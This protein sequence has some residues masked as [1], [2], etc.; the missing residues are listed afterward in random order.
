MK[1]Q[2]FLSFVKTLRP[3]ESLM[4]YVEMFQVIAEVTKLPLTGERR[5]A[6]CQSDENVNHKFQAQNQVAQV[7]RKFSEM[8]LCHHQTLPSHILNIKTT[9]LEVA[10]VKRK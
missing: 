6:H 9:L 2:M 1:I 3:C 5:I 4:E 10:Q 7:K 8:P